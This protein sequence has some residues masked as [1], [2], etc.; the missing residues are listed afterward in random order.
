MSKQISGHTGLLCLLGSPVA[1]SISPAMH[2]KACE[3]LD[4]DY[5]YLAFDVKEEEMAD[6]IKALKLMNAK[7]WNVTMPG[8]N[9]MVELADEVSLASEIS[10]SANTVVN[11]NGKLY[12]TTT[13]GIG[14]MEA[15]KENDFDLSQKTMTLMGAGGAATAILVQAALSGLKEIHVFNVKDGFYQR[16]LEIVE[17]LNKKNR[18]QG[19][20]Q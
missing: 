2:N 11:E 17:K 19:E 8:K 4:L 10:G 1:H 9:I 3:L 7:G 14:F 6:A 15:V 16:A 5:A 13:D 12:A 18:L 20:P